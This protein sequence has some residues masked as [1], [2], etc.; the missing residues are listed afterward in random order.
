MNSQINRIR[1]NTVPSS[2]SQNRV[3]IVIDAA[4]TR[5]WRQRNAVDSIAV[6]GAGAAG[7]APTWVAPTLQADAASK[8]NNGA[9]QMLLECVVE[10]A[11]DDWVDAT[12]AVAQQL[13]EEEQQ[14]VRIAVIRMEQCVYLRKQSS[15]QFSK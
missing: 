13:R 2:I 15:V 6:G 14:P 11:V 9:V 1:V 10:E 8:L 3:A 7:A 4:V 12:V 5:E